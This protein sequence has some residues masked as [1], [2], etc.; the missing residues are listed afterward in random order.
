MD[1]G[2][3]NCDV[4]F[5]HGCMKIQTL[6][7]H[8][9]LKPMINFNNSDDIDMNWDVKNCD[10]SGVHC[11]MNSN[12]LYKANNNNYVDYT[13]KSDQNTPNR[14]EIENTGLKDGDDI[15]VM[16]STS[17]LNKYANMEYNNE[18]HPT[19]VNGK[20]PQLKKHQFLH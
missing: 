5:R 18:N 6:C 9:G 17:T 8:N 12:T 3:E 7:Q 13:K 11:F 14:Y 2:V 15:D 19:L 4:S 10:M 16:L 20:T 1:G